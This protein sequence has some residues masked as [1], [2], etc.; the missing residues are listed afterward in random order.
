MEGMKV[1]IELNEDISIESIIGS[2]EEVK[3][4]ISLIGK[5]FSYATVNIDDLKA[6]LRKMT[7]K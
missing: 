3:V 4:N 7:E 2:N 6:A 5:G 1:I